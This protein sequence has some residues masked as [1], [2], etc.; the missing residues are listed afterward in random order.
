MDC[1]GMEEWAADW[2][3]RTQPCSEPCFSQLLL[4]LCSCLLSPVLMSEPLPCLKSSTL[5]AI[6]SLIFFFSH[7][8]PQILQ[9]PFLL[10]TLPGPAADA[11]NI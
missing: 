11:Q 6:Q 2:S 8:L 7:S 5:T 9:P 3:K 10:L 4:K 1:C